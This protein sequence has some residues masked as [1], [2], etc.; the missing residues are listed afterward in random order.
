MVDHDR[1][2]PQDSPGSDAGH[3]MDW[4]LNKD[5]FDKHLNK[6]QFL[7]F[8]KFGEAAQTALNSTL[9]QVCSK[10]CCTEWKIEVTC[11]NDVGK[12]LG[13]SLPANLAAAATAGLCGPSNTRT[14]KGKCESGKPLG[15][16]GIQSVINALVSK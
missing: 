1:E 12:A 9:S 7:D 4:G 13:M 15:I 14:W 8:P 6:D 2:H 10:E 16:E 11:A 5:T 3:G